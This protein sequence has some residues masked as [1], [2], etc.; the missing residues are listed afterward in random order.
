MKGER[1]IYC[2]M[3]ITEDDIIEAMRDIDGYFDITTADARE[4]FRY[5]YRHAIT[6][7]NYAL[8]ARDIMTKDVAF[9]KEST[10]LI[11]VAALMAR[12]AIS[13]VPVSGD[14]GQVV[15]VISE[16][17]FFKHMGAKDNTNLMSV[18]SAFLRGENVNTAIVSQKA[19]DIMSKP[20][21][22]IDEDA[23]MATITRVLHENRINRVPVLDKHEHLTGIVTR[24]DIIRYFCHPKV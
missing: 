18:I 2:E 6:R 24:G 4:I 10:P 3:D 5:A 20:A 13:G 17:D 16:K 11:E 12:T 14:T 9:V 1:D 22:T 19:A 21:V 15:G 23:P 7:L 8:R